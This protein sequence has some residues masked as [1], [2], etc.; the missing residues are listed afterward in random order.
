MWYYSVSI[1]SLA[2]K[3]ITRAKKYEKRLAD[4]IPNFWNIRS[5]Y[6]CLTGL[7]FLL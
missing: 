7:T 2:A 3:T 5:L 1:K 4:F 6:H